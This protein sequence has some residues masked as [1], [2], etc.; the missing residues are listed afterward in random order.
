MGMTLEHIQQRG[1]SYRYRRKVPQGLRAIVGK[2]EIV[3][4]LGKTKA[5]A[6]K[7]Y[8]EFHRKAE[9]NPRSGAWDEHQGITKAKPSLSAREKFQRTVDE[10][11]AMGFN[12][13]Q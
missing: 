13:Y 4:P 10:I 9:A 8:P 2:G 6:V 3:F 5:A 12:P 1:N 7:A 11:G